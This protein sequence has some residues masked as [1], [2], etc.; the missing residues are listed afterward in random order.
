MIGLG[1]FQNFFRW[2]QRVL[3]S[4]GV[5]VSG[6]SAKL[7]VFRTVSAFSIDNRANVKLIGTKMLTDCIGTFAQF[8]KRLP[9][10]K[11]RFLSGNLI[12][13]QHFVS[14]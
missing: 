9:I 7:T 12:F 3:G 11:Q 5:I 1:L 14:Y 13:A 4:A 6:L 2:K 10:Q 8:G